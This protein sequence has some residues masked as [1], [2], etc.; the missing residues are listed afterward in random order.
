MIQYKLYFISGSTSCS[1]GDTLTIGLDEGHSK[2]LYQ[3]TYADLDRI[4][5]YAS[6]THSEFTIVGIEL[7]QENTDP[8]EG[9]LLQ[10]SRPADDPGQ[11]LSAKREIDE[12]TG[13]RSLKL[14]FT[15]PQ[16]F[17]SEHFWHFTDT[18]A[19]PPLHLKVKVKRQESYN[20][21]PCSEWGP[22][23]QDS[24]LD[25]CSSVTRR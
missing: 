15:T 23:M 6:E 13:Q 14:S 1:F 2:A 17:E 8:A 4:E 24:V 3:G 19:P 25:V 11:F 9:I 18:Q 5:V 7:S 20:T 10:E 16:N 22:I 21:D 12:T